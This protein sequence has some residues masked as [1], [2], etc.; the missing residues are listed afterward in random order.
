[1]A[2]S[3][4]LKLTSKM[5]VTSHFLSVSVCLSDHHKEFDGDETVRVDCDVVPDVVPALCLCRGL[6]INRAEKCLE[7]NEQLRDAGDYQCRLSSSLKS[8]ELK[9]SCKTVD[10]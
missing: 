9:S 6:N 8:V 10:K 5:S 1:M 3:S 2:S 7:W 4:S